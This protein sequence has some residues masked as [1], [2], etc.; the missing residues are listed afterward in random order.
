MAEMFDILYS[1]YLYTQ[2]TEK[3]KEFTVSQSSNL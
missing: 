2:S 1:L 3:T